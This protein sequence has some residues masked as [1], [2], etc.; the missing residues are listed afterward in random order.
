M[1]DSGKVADSDKVETDKKKSDNKE[2]G[3]KESGKEDSG[4]ESAKMP[5]A[6]AETKDDTGAS[7]LQ[8]HI[9][10]V[11]KDPNYR[12]LTKEEYDLLVNASLKQGKTSTP[13]VKTKISTMEKVLHSAGKPVHF[14]F[15]KTPDIPPTPTC[16]IS[17]QY[18]FPKLPT[19]S[20]ADD[21]KQGEVKYE[22]WNFEVKCL[23]NS[24]QYPEH[25]LLQSV[26]NSL[27]GLAR[28]ML[29]SIGENASLK[30][31]LTKLDGFFG[32][33][34]S[35]ETLM[36]SFYND[37]QK[38]GESLVV[39]A[40]RLEDTLSKAIKY[41]HI[42]AVAKDG[43]LRSKFW[44]GLYN[45]QLKQSTRHLFDSVK[46]FEYLL[47]EIRKVQQ[48]E[49][50]T[51]V[52]KTQR[53]FQQAERAETTDLQKELQKLTSTM[54]RLESKSDSTSQSFQQLSSKVNRLEK[55]SNQQSPNFSGSSRGRARGFGFRGN[56]SRGYVR[57]RGQFRG[58]GHFSVNENQTQ[59]NNQV[60][61]K[62]NNSTN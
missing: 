21:S 9:S 56:S 52:R 37:M 36:Q 1:A 2:S 51:P 10:E 6:K 55:M 33:V 59:S 60:P 16:T 32:N 47:R 12:V 48:E 23:Q 44:T 53:A 49:L 27:K 30:D 7:S 24:G 5:L 38:E 25:I 8:H 35:G 11:Q 61:Q 43:M 62:S 22:V 41:G 4:K 45:V 20:G 31:I 50:S 29:V 39:Y 42:D 14:D 19:F 17:T 3:K 34:A 26:R 57:R 15:P 13:L 54:Q 18:N 28:S 40:S 58:Q 46:N